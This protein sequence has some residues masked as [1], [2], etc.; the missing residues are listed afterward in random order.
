MKRKEKKRGGSQVITDS[1]RKIAILRLSF[2][3]FP[4]EAESGRDAGAEGRLLHVGGR[5][6]RGL[7]GN[8]WT[9]L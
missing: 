2:A 5:R 1:A 4:T 9:A 3:V 8:M 6:T 7:R